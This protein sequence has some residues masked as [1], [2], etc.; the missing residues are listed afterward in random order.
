[1][2]NVGSWD[3]GKTIVR[4]YLSIVAST[5]RIDLLS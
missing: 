1:M 3:I 2:A 5:F 4:S